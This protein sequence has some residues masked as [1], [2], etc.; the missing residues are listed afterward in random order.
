MKLSIIVTTYNSE[1]YIKECI[2]SVICALDSFTDYQIIIVDNNSYDKTINIINELDNDKIEIIKQNGN[3]GYSFSVNNGVSKSKF[4]KILI[5]NPDTVVLDN[6]I[7]DLYNASENSNIGVVGAKLVNTDGSFQLSSRRHFPTLG[8]LFSYVFRLNRI[9]ARNSYFGQYNYTYLNDNLEYEV[10]AV[11][12]ACMIFPKK[13]YYDVGGFDEIFFIYFE[14]TDFCYK[15][16]DKKY[17]VLYYPKAKVMHHNNF[18]D[19]H[20]SKNF[21]FYESFE[22]FIYKYKNKICLG[23]L[24]Y[25]LAKLT[26]HIFNLKRQLAVTR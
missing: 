25:Y 9:F 11:S 15:I 17:K 4:K 16:K 2:E 7:F 24:V 21:Y 14:D 3:K 12:G 1:K 18:S 10:D 19:N 23:L 22:K 8:I 26:K 6:A 20:N 13:A 5:L